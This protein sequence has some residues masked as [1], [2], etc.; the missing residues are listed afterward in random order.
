MWIPEGYTEVAVLGERVTLRWNNRRLLNRSGRHICTCMRPQ[1]TKGKHGRP[2]MP[3]PETCKG[4]GWSVLSRSRRSGQR[5]CGSGHPPA[6]AMGTYTTQDPPLRDRLSLCPPTGLPSQGASLR[7]GFAPTQL[8]LTLNT[9]PAWGSRCSCSGLS[10]S[11]AE[12]TYS[13]V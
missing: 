7:T 5:T 6:A 10:P 11:A 12:V 4:R 8:A 3:R 1:P 9:C 2:Q 13:S